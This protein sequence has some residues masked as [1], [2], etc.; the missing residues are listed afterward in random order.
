L[1]SGGK[2]PACVRSQAGAPPQR[3]AGSASSLRPHRHYQEEGILS[4]PAFNRSATFS[5]IIAGQLGFN[6]TNFIAELSA[7]I[8]QSN[9]RQRDN[10]FSQISFLSSKSTNN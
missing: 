4:L 7:A 6:S 5:N 2:N 3:G 1:L 10:K 9:S 8:F